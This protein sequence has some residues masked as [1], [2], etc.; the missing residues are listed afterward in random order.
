MPETFIIYKRMYDA[1]LRERLADRYT[2]KTAHDCDLA[3]EWWAKFSSLPHEKA[4]KAKKIIAL[5]R[6]Y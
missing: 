6:S 3:N 4:A 1:D 2:S 5:N